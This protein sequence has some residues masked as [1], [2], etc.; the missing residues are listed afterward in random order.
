MIFHGCFR[1]SCQILYLLVLGSG[2]SCFGS[3]SLC[4]Q[5]N[6]HPRQCLLGHSTF[7][8]SAGKFQVEGSVEE[9]KGLS[10]TSSKFG[11]SFMQ[12][13][14]WIV[15]YNSYG[16][17][18]GYTAVGD[19]CSSVICMRCMFVCVYINHYYVWAR[20]TLHRI[21]PHMYAYTTWP[22]YLSYI[23]GLHSDTYLYTDNS[24]MMCTVI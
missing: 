12:K 22:N 9:G 21:L 15:Q 18:Y 14:V 13:H 20:N 23:Y 8:V 16:H 24:F 7:G 3:T 4:P 6:K 5:P 1:H 11:V 10:P 17:S 2:S 19:E